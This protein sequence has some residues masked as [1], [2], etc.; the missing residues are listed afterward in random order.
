M[1]DLSRF[2]SEVEVFSDL[3]DDWLMY[4]SKSSE[5]VEYKTS[6][7]I[8][9]TGELYR[10]IWIVYKGKVEI[11]GATQDSN[12]LFI[13]N[14]NCG[15]VFGEMSVMVDR[16]VIEDMTAIEDTTVIKLPRDVFSQVIA[17]NPSTLKKIA[18]IVTER[19]RGQ[20]TQPRAVY[21]SRL[22]DNPDPY[23]LNLSSAKRAIKLLIINCGSSSLKYSLFDTSSPQPMFEGLIENIGTEASPHKIKTVNVKMQRPEVVRDIREA[24]S[25]MVN[26]LTD[27]AIGIIADFNEIQAVGHRVVHGGN[28]FSASAVIT[29]EVKEAIRSCEPLAP[30]HNPYNLAGI[31]VMSGLLPNAVSVA[32]FDTAFHQSM[33][34]E[35]YQ[36]AIPYQLAQERHVRRYGFHGTNHHFVALM[37]SVFVKRPLENLKIISCHLGNGASICAIDGGR[38]VDTSMGLTPL[39]GLVMGTRCGDIDPG[40]VLY[41]L[42]TGLSVGSL[43]KT[44]NKDSGLKG[45]SG[46][47][48]DMREIL[49]AAEEGNAKAEATLRMFCYRVR[50]YIGAYIAALGGLDILIFTGGIGENSSEVR[51]RICQGLDGLGISLDNGVNR[52]AKVARGNIANLSTEASSVKVLAVAADEERMIAREIIRSVSS[53]RA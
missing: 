9:Q 21:K 48:N 29:D 53:L 49:N 22:M 50:K 26:A 3:N 10:Y 1:D 19:Q 42:Q 15:D 44:L 31:E 34:S 37:A 39:E 18:C 6:Q 11:V 14:L 28:Q 8:I 46:I 2:L 38:S 25:V 5:L 7:Q 24:F 47:S 45:I 13:T 30:L 36:Y 43:E 12:R 4:L 33:P 32:V 40:L 35:A 23:D 41:L 16:P 27:K 51:A 17:Q 20:K 52:I